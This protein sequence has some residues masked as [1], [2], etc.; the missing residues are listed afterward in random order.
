[1]ITRMMMEI[2]D[3]NG[4]IKAMIVVMMMIVQIIDDN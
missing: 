1:M 2:I 3:D 4:L